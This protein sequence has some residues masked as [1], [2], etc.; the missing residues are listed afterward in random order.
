LGANHLNKTMQ[1]DDDHLVFYRVG[2]RAAD[3]KATPVMTGAAEDIK[4]ESMSDQCAWR[5]GMS[6]KTLFGRGGRTNYLSSVKIIHSQPGISPC[7]CHSRAAALES[8][9]K[10]FIFCFCCC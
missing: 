1:P 4:E 2:G 6:D 9:N 10:L 7:Y 5:M 8:L 3:I